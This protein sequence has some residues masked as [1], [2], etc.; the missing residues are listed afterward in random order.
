[1]Y[2]QSF[3]F[4]RSIME[5]SIPHFRKRSA[6]FSNVFGTKNLKSLTLEITKCG[7]FDLIFV[8]GTF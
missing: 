3:I 5:V 8:F 6:S 2:W 7:D 1:M 4:D